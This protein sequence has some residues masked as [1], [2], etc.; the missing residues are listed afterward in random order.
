MGSKTVHY[1]YKIKQLTNS[2]SIIHLTALHIAM[3]TLAIINPNNQIKLIQ[4][5]LTS[6]MFQTLHLVKIYIMLR[7]IIFQVKNN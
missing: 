5:M 3:K 1:L 4:F 7:L 6:T 2:L